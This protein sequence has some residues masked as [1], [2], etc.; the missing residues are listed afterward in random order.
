[1]LTHRATLSQVDTKINNLVGFADLNGGPD[2]H[3]RFTAKLFRQSV[4]LGRCISVGWHV[5]CRQIMVSGFELH[6]QYDS[7]QNCEF[8]LDV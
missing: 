7:K 6:D 2:R 8:L 1:M 4:G 3:F 5:L